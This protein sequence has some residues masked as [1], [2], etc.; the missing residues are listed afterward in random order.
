M[1]AGF[2]GPLVVD[3]GPVSVASPPFSPHL[4]HR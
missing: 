1:T 2:P 3:A 4:W